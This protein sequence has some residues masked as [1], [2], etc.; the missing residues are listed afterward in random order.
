MYWSAYAVLG[1]SPEATKTQIRK[2]YRRLAKLYHPDVNAGDT[3]KAEQFKEVQRAYES[4]ADARAVRRHGPRPQ[5]PPLSDDEDPFLRYLVAYLARKHQ[6]GR[7][8]WFSDA[9]S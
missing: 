1:L 3:E 8:S 7:S 2:A 9:E 6:G 4:L 5:Q